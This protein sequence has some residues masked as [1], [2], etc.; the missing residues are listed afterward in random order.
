MASQP[1]QEPEPMVVSSDMYNADE[2]V[3]MLERLEINDRTVFVTHKG[4]PDVVSSLA[5]PKI[6]GVDIVRNNYQQIKEACQRTI[7]EKIS[8][9]ARGLDFAHQK[10]DG[11]RLTRVEIQMITQGTIDVHFIFDKSIKWMESSGLEQGNI[12]LQR[13]SRSEIDNSKEPLPLS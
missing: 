11:A 4:A 2:P 7:S 6:D 5:P 3:N 9:R 10:G 8:G 12:V 13:L 1:I